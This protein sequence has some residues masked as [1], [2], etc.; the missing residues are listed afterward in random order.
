MDFLEGSWSSVRINKGMNKISSSNLK[1]WYLKSHATKLDRSIRQQKQKRTNL[2][3]GCAN[4]QKKFIGSTKKDSVFFSY[5]DVK[6]CYES[7]KFDEKRRN[8]T[9][10]TVK[11]VLDGF[12]VFKEHAKQTPVKGFTF[13]PLDLDAELEKLRTTKFS[14]DYKFTKATLNLVTE[15]K[16]PHTL[17]FPICYTR[18][19]FTQKLLLYS[20]VTNGAQKIKVL[21]DIVDPSNND[22]EVK[23]INGVPALKTISD[24]ARDNVFVSKDHGVRFNLALTSLSL[25]ND[26]YQIQP[27]SSQFTLRFI[28]PE[29]ETYTYTLSCKKNNNKI[30]KRK[31]E[32]IANSNDDLNRFTDSK[33][34]WKNI[35]TNPDSTIPPAPLSA[36]SKSNTKK[37]KPFKPF[38]HSINADPFGFN[39]NHLLLEESE[40]K[41]SKGNLVHSTKLGQF[42]MLDDTVGVAAL[43][44][45]NLDNPSDSVATIFNDLKT[46][47]TQLANKGAKK[48]ILDLSNNQGGLIVFSHFVNKLLFPESDP[49]LP[50]DMRLTNIMKTTVKTISSKDNPNSF[51]DSRIWISADTQKPFSNVE[52]FLGTGDQKFTS[53]F[54]DNDITPI[55]KFLTSS[56]EPQQLP[57]KSEDIAILTNG[58][59]GS[60]CALVASQ[61]AE[62]HQVTTVSVGGFLNKELSFASFVGGQVTL[63]KNPF[64]GGDLKT[65]L[66]NSGAIDR[67]DA[68]N[69]FP[70]NVLLTFA[71]RE[72]YSAKNPDEVLEYAFRPSNHQLFYDDISI[73]DQSKLWS[74]AATF[75]N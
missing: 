21:K 27:T 40:V 74:Q 41:L 45:L 47:F 73:K 30:V 26:Q 17:F 31:W 7:F 2:A 57:W 42:F 19:T 75:I 14:N 64:G 61:L 32:A 60:S 37:S 59:C 55:N 65:D 69:E 53:K 6:T 13:N 12:Y 48:L 50:T 3:D 68:P 16:D 24:F 51:F 70:T 35:C 56:G 25:Q 62:K 52:E 20:V 4:I 71:F 15:F 1:A 58:F 33:S 44:S 66:V 34:Y 38:Q 11:N 9:I 63:W 5:A 39:T 54:L 29:R 23:T 49:S 28:V 67:Q 8:D 18:F 43:S 72:A 10:N 36:N 46:G 22:C